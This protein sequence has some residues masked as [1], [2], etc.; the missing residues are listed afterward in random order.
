MKAIDSHILEKN[1]EAF[2]DELKAKNGP[3]LYQIPLEEARSLL[4]KI[5]AAPPK[6]ARVSIEERVIPLGEGRLLSL[7]VVRP[8]G[9]VDK[10]P[11]ILYFHGGGWV[12]GS[13]LTHERLVSELA[14]SA[15]AVV[16]FINYTRSPE[17]KFPIAIEECYATLKYIYEHGDEFQ[18]NPHHLAVVGDSAG[19]NMAIAMTLLAKE[20][21]G[22]KIDYQVLF[23]PVTCADLYTASYRQFA[24]GPWLTK[25]AM[26]WFWN[27]YE[28]DSSKRK[29][30]LLSPLNATLEQLRELPPALVITAENDVL[31]DEGEAYALQLIQAGVNVTAVRFLGTIHDFVMLNPLTNTPAT[32]SAIALAVGYLRQVLG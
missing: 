12:L 7:K 28:P 5:Q 2:I 11:A 22:P 27:C 4:E 31:R 26:E 29:K 13:F 19:G 25:K 1:T 30:I 18:C 21:N 20:R 9:V 3:P 23:Y 16:I 15:H 14:A 8:Q 10:L 17:A 32:R 24:E 6:K